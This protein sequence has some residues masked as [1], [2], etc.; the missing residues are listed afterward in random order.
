MAKKR[1]SLKD[2]NVFKRNKDTDVDIDPDLSFSTPDSGTESEVA[3]AEDKPED[4]SPD[5]L[6][7]SITTPPSEPSSPTKKKNS[8]IELTN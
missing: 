6:V 7:L 2:K 1:T 4:A 8:T 5:K 3:M